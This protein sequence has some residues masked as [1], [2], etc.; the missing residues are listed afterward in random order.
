MR[1]FQKVFILLT[2]L[3]AISCGKENQIEPQEQSPD[4]KD[5][6]E[7]SILNLL[8][9]NYINHYFSIPA[10]ERG[11][12]DPD[13]FI[14]TYEML[15]EIAELILADDAAQPF[16][17]N[18]LENYGSF[19]WNYSFMKKQDDLCFIS[20]P[21]L[22]NGQ[23]SGV[24]KFYKKGDER[25]LRFVS[26][27]VIDEIVATYEFSGDLDLL[28]GAMFDLFILEASI[29]HT[30]NQDYAEWLRRNQLTNDGSSRGEF[31][32]IEYITDWY[33]NVALDGSPG[34][35]WIYDGS[36]TSLEC[37]FSTSVGST[38]T[39]TNFFPDNYPPNNEGNGGSNTNTNTNTNT[40]SNNNTEPNTPQEN[41]LEE[42]GLSTQVY[43]NELL[44]SSI[45]FPCGG[46]IEEAVNSAAMYLIE[47]GQCE[48]LGGLDA[49][50]EGLRDFDFIRLDESFV[51][52]EKMNCVWNSILNS[53]NDIMCT[54]LSNFFGSSSY[55]IDFY[56]Q[57]FP[58]N[59][60]QATTTTSD[61]GGGFVTQF[62]QD[63]VNE[64]CP[65]E[66]LETILH[67]AIHAEILRR[68][69]TY[70]LA[71]QEQLFP[72]MM[73][74]LTDPSL[75]DWQHEYMA[76]EWFDSLLE[77]VINFYPS[78]FT[79]DQYEA[80]VWGGLHETN[81]FE[82]NSGMTETELDNK[83]DLI[84]TNCDQSCD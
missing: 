7:I 17:D 37:F 77:A 25:A 52:N 68:Q 49:F 46:S 1:G 42:L 33:V 58:A 65:V 57:D 82:Q 66:L 56:V 20:I 26:K 47:T 70:T 22:K 72:E 38:G 61:Q 4:T 81:A 54:T 21:M 14:P 48:K 32:C 3:I 18:F 62:N 73:L 35:D 10:Q 36:S 51:S 84:R 74:Y 64:A 13:D 5:S 40:N 43:I 71:E 69:F 8:E 39:T 75:S 23:L 50:L 78:G 59:P 16:L 12:V 83:I 45:T 63:Y 34:G 27:L 24:L 67:E 15:N 44:N 28:K 76:N 2:L 55:D 9:A 60:A 80:I 6:E 19:E 30:F 31:W 53:N 11:E 29:D 41:C 79:L